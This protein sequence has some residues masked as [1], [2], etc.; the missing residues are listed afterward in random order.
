MLRWQSNEKR[1]FLPELLL[2]P[3]SFLKYLG[4]VSKQ[5]GAYPA[6]VSLME[7][8]ANNQEA[9]DPAEVSL[10]EEPANNQVR[11]LTSEDSELP[12]LSMTKNSI[13]SIYTPDPR[14]Q[15]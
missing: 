15:V 2:W 4:R 3:Y 7:E 6:E 11:N 8:P 1:L 12:S 5:V 9:E 13:Y 10:M 14:T